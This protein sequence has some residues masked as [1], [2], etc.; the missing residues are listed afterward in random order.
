MD[1]RLAS[2][3]VARLRLKLRA[4]H[5]L[6]VCAAM[7][8]NAW[9]LTDCEVYRTTMKSLTSLGRLAPRIL[10]TPTSAAPSP[11]P[12]PALPTA[13]SRLCARTTSGC[14]FDRSLL[15]TSCASGVTSRSASSWCVELLIFV[16][17][18]MPTYDLQDLTMLDTR[19]YDRDLTD[20][21]YNTECTSA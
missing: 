12:A 10:T 8:Y 19:Q 7:S 21:Y 17:T 15:M 18:S 13:S 6:R 1:H 9:F 11:P 14:L 4:D 16:R 5:P 2:L 20:L 3:H